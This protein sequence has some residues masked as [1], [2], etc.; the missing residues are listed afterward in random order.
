MSG[1]PAAGAAG[2]GNHKRCFVQKGFNIG[3]CA[4][5]LKGSESGEGNEHMKQPLSTPRVRGSKG[6]VAGA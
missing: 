5:P 1:V 2:N 4:E 6:T 3:N